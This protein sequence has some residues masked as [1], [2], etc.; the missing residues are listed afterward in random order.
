M[1]RYARA[2]G[3]T[4]VLPGAVVAVLLTAYFAAWIDGRQYYDPL[5]AM[6]YFDH[7][8]RVPAVTLGALVV[9]ILATAT[10]HR[11]DEQVEGSTPRPTPTSELLTVLA[12]VGVGA[13]LALALIRT[14]PLERGG[15]ELVRN[16]IGLTGLALIGTALLGT[17]LGWLLPFTVTGVSY[18]AVTRAYNHDPEQ[19]VL[20]WIMFPATWRITVVVAVLLLAVGIV[21]HRLAGGIPRPRRHPLR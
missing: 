20:G 18:F 17:R 1:T 7:W 13:L 14:H 10:L 6:I 11:T 9:A 15:L 16:L 12:I 3:L 21:L 5:G 4:W 2:R 8:G 19:A